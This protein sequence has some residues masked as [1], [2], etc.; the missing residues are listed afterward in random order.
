MAF[1][2]KGALL[3]PL[4]LLLSI[5]MNHPRLIAAYLSIM[6]SMPMITFIPKDFSSRLLQQQFWLLEPQAAISWL[7]IIFIA[8][9]LWLRMLSF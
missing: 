6:A 4:W 7:H 1:S 3:D 8:V 5:L 2:L 9:F